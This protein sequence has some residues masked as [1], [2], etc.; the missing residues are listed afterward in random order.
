MS[1]C[2]GL[3]YTDYSDRPI[4]MIDTLLLPVVFLAT[5][6]GCRVLIYWSNKR[7]W[8]D[9]PSSRSSHTQPTPTGGGLAMV[10]S[11]TCACLIAFTDDLSGFNQYMILVPAI[12]IAGVGLADDIYQLGIMPRIAVQALAAVWALALFGMP[13]IPLFS[14]TVI[15]ELMGYL[16]AIVCFIWFINLFN[17]MDGIDG[18]A[19]SQSLFMLMAGVILALNANAP[20]LITLMLLLAAA[21]CGFLVLNIS[22][23]RIFMGDVGSNFLGFLL[24]VIVLAT[25]VRGVVTIWSWLILSGVFIIDAS[26]TLMTRV[27]AGEKWY[28]AHR[29]H[30]YQRA[31]GHFGSHGKVVLLVSAI[32]C[33]WLLPLAWAAH[34]FQSAGMMWLVVAWIPLV[35]LVRFIARLGVSTQP[36]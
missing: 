28:Y 9:E 22:P 25:T 23:A 8:L 6:L 24:G 20:D 17:F 33:F 36:S 27:L 1:E 30:A 11:F 13:P 7:Q 14:M 26:V 19:G 18:I 15:P 35:C 10:F 2:T 32:N 31:A 29:S 12:L 34:I 5:F 16:V 4:F 21:V 3:K